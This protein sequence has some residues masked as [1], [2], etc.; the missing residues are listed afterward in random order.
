VLGN[1]PMNGFKVVLGPR[2][3]TVAQEQIKKL[4]ANNWFDKYTVALVAEYNL[5]N[6]WT[7]SFIL[8]KNVVELD[9]GGEVLSKSF[10]YK[11]LIQV[12][13]SFYFLMIVLFFVQIITFSL[14]VLVEISLI[15]NKFIFLGQII[16]IFLQFFCATMIAFRFSLNFNQS[17]MV[18]DTASSFGFLD[19]VS[20]IDIYIKYLFFGLF[21]LY[22]FRIFQL[23]SWS[24]HMSIIVKFSVTIYRT[25]PSLTLFFFLLLLIVLIWGQ[26]YF[27][28]FQDYL[29]QFRSYSESIFNLYYINF[30]HIDPISKKLIEG[31]NSE[32]FQIMW[33]LQNISLAII[34]FFF[35]ALLMDLFRRSASYEMPQITPSERETEEMM[36]QYQLKFDKFMKELNSHFSGKK[37]NDNNN[38]FSRT[39]TKILIWLD[40]SQGM[41]ESE[42]DIIAELKE[43]NIKIM[44]FFQTTEVIQFL[45]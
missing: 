17:P 12:N 11:V 35:I 28:F 14:K 26:A 15:F 32:M 34:L 4:K 13:D 21:I 27:F 18:L 3:K 5:Y 38:D 30:G 16:H 31:S 10:K 8:V 22:P 6:V 24:K 33:F 25:L 44:S 1:Y 7:E 42:E 39:Q 19:Y 41:F 40:P 45:R 20:S 43:N 23:L 2:D 36:L 29:Y 37:E 9:G